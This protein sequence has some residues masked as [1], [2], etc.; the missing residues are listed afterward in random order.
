MI[1]KEDKRLLEPDL[2]ALIIS[3][4]IDNKKNKINT[5]INEFTV[6]S[7]TR[8]VDLAIIKNNELHAY[9]V[10]SSAD[11][12]ERLDGQIKEYI[13]HFDKVT[14]VADS[15]HIS[16]ILN[17]TPEYIS[18]W[19]VKDG[20]IKIKRRG[21]KKIIT[22]KSVFIKYFSL[23]DLYKIIKN[24][25]IKINNNNNRDDL[26]ALAITISI[27]KLREYAI[28]TI[29]SKYKMTSNYFIKK[30]SC[31]KIIPSDLLLLRLNDT[32]KNEVDINILNET[33]IR[34]LCQL[35]E[36]MDEIKY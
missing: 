14:I 24:E 8:R 34:D 4:V 20:K 6:S 21:R 22:D 36:E 33:I 9:E 11:T 17:I 15:K 19:E 35:K 7:F 23:N 29:K 28:N 12:L 1:L 3:K 30:I 31:G 25:N 32:I 18:V 5:I 2:K 13:K 16:K 27:G 10:K 26:E